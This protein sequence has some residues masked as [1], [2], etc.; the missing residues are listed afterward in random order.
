MSPN[1]G[2]ADEPLSPTDSWS[3]SVDALP[4]GVSV[5]L[6][7]KGGRTEYLMGEPIVLHLTLAGDSSD[8]EVNTVTTFGVSEMIHVTPAGPTFRWHGTFSGDVVDL[9][10]L[11]ESGFSIS[12]LL[13]EAI[14]LK[15]PGTYTVSVSTRRI[16]QADQRRWLTLTSNPVTIHV[17]PMPEQEEARRVAALSEAIAMTDHSDGLD[18]ATEVELACLEGDIAA[19]KKVSLYLTGR[20]DIT[21]IRKTGL[22]LSKN[23]QL[24]LQLLDEAWR[25]IVRIPGSSLLDEMIELRHLKAGIATPDIH[26]IAPRLTKDEVVRE[27]AERTS[28]INEIGASMA[29]RRGANKSATEGFLNEE[30]KYRDFLLTTETDKTP[31]QSR[32]SSR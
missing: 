16:F 11:S 31:Q 29:L 23:K 3:Q 6:E 4:S 8:Y 5:R 19:R 28:Y 12:L 26:P 14:I 1:Y 20:D 17:A 27:L 9:T 13:N 18:H 2:L 15:E 21:G 10:P 32:S 7:P 25:S 30:K 24:E 22:A